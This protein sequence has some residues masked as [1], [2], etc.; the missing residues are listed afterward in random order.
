LFLGVVGTIVMAR[1][2]GTYNVMPD[3]KVPGGLGAV[4]VYGTEIAPA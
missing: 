2:D 4:Y 1:V 3:K